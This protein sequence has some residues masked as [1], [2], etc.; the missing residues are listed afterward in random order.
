MSA[1]LN[2]DIKKH[3][4]EW[5]ARKNV[6]KD[7][8]RLLEKNRRGQLPPNFSFLSPEQVFWS[9]KIIFKN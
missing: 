2:V 7:S 8:A 9:P 1:L 5:F 4:V 6:L 3:N